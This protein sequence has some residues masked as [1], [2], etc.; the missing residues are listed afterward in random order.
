MKYVMYK[1]Y[2]V[3][4]NGLV[5]SVKK[6]KRFLKPYNVGK[7]YLSVKIENKNVYVHK[8]VAE[9]FLGQRPNDFT[10]NHKDGNKANNHFSNLEYISKEDNYKHA[11][12]NN[13]KRNVFKTFTPEELSDMAEFYCNTNH[14]MKEICSWFG[15][16]RGVLNRVLNGKH[17]YIY[18]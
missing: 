8:I 18:G 17:K 4:E 16:D 13:L 2:R 10:V 11:L 14:S 15:F 12:N 5:F 1:E 7:G 3:Y 9:C 6:G